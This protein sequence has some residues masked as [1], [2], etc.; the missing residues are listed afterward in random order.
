MIA[1]KLPKETVSRLVLRP[2]YTKP[3]VDDP[4]G[5]WGSQL[6]SVA[7]TARIGKAAG[8]IRTCMLTNGYCA[9]VGGLLYRV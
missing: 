9:N 1:A 5:L 6:L 4:S 7:V 2:R 3:A 8:V